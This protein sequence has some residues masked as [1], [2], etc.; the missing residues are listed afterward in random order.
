MK[1]SGS[2]ALRVKA[3]L[4]RGFGDSSR[5]AIVQALTGGPRTVGDIAR[6]TGLSQP[7]VS[8]HLMCMRC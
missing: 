8:M 2:A 4:F 1:A 7:L 5:L 6:R 3:K